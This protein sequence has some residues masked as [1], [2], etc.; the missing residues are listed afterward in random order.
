M[1]TQQ[2]LPKI[3]KATK[4]KDIVKSFNPMPLTEIDMD[5][6]VETIQER[7][8]NPNQSPLKK[9]FE[10]V[11]SGSEK[12]ACIL[13]GHRGSGKSTELNNLKIQFEN[14][15][16]QTVV[17]D[18]EKE[19]DLNTINYWDIML[20]ITDAIINIAK[21]NKISLQED[22][23]KNIFNVF[24]KI[25]KLIEIV[26]SD[27]VSTEAGG[28]FSL[29]YFAELFIKVKS[30]YSKD[31][32]VKTIIKEN[33]GYKV[34]DWQ[35]LIEQI[36]FQ[37]IPHLKAKRPILIFESLDKITD[38]ERLINMFKNSILAQMKFPVIYTAPISMSY[39]KNIGEIDYLYN[40]K[41]LPT[42]KVKNIDNSINQSA[43]DIIKDIIYSRAEE[44]LFEEAGLDYL[45]E[46]T[47]GVIRQVF[48]CINEASDY[49]RYE[50]NDIITK[51]YFEDALN[52]LRKWL[53][54][55]VEGKDFKKLL[56]INSDKNVVDETDM[57]L[58]FMQRQ[59]VLEYENGKNWYDVHPLIL[60][61]LK[62]DSVQRY[63]ERK[64]G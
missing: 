9:I 64:N 50:N 45:I 53:V 59:I 30:S 27:K 62:S 5:L 32:A 17:I 16:H 35:F 19:S 57:L 26:D 58:D 21:E 48:E 51:K 6:Y 47:G 24:N 36:Y 33:I 54:R 1:A 28:G 25:D 43:V 4:I 46:K 14:E 3:T 18:C 42:I 40:I 31:Y 55:T 34:A 23:V 61:Y 11:T 22:D 37:I 10:I 56:E 20:L 44:T 39:S 49:A 29:K 2:N 41:R 63:L 7:T 60:D 38:S 52:E 13:I 12:S 15:F 8:N